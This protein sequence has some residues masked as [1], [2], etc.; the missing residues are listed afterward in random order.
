MAPTNDFTG[1]G[2]SRSSGDLTIQQ[3]I[4]LSPFELKEP[5]EIRVI[6][7][8]GGKTIHIR[9]L[10]VQLQEGQPARPTTDANEAP[11]Q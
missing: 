11:S 8:R 9:R 10:D 4:V 2:V 7:K 5:G 3:Q 1:L 6:A